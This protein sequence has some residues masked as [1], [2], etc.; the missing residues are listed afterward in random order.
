MAE[1]KY[2]ER[3]EW[4]RKSIVDVA[5]DASVEILRVEGNVGRKL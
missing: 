2:V 4:D 1:R 3:V 5:L